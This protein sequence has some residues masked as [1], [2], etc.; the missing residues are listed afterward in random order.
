MPNDIQTRRVPI[1]TVQPSA[2]PVRVHN[3]HQ[4]RKIQRLLK[5]HGQLRPIIV[6]PECNIVD[7]EAV[8]AEMR[9]LGYDEIDIVVVENASPAELRALRL[10]LNR[11]PEDTKWDRAQLRQEFADLIELGFDMELT[12]FETVEIEQSL[13]IDEAP[14]DVVEEVAAA[15]ITPPALIVGQP[16][17]I[18]QLGRHTLACGSALDGGLVVRLVGPGTISAVFTDP[19][20]NVPIGGHVSGLGKTQH[21]EFAMASGE[22]STA[23]F[24][25]F[26]ATAL[27]AC[28]PC[29]AD[30]AILYVAMDWRHVA[31]LAEAGRACGLELKN[32]C[33]WVKTN[34]GMG[35]FYRSQHELIFVFK[36]GTGP[37]QNNFGLG[38]H[39]RHR[40]NVW[41]YAGVNTFGKDRMELL[42]AHPTVKPMQM[43]IDALKDVT[44]RG[45][46]VFDPFLGSGSTLLAAEGT[47]RSC[48]GIELDPGYV[49]I[50]IR[51]WQKLTGKDAVHAETG[52]TFDDFRRRMLQTA[53]GREP[54]GGP[55]S[56]T[57]LV[58]LSL[59]GSEDTEHV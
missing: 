34:A 24:T 58:P 5:R 57:D 56:Q 12:G 59:T 52:E 6:D 27:G 49:E 44:R 1:G 43:I 2:K 50:A 4:R 22:M 9:E 38:Q 39:G 40:T 48:I 26:L 19:P 46:V 29:L 41:R 15:E 11:I 28:T 18:W 47:V 8:Y 32:I 51:R 53:A 33:V 20:Y 42:G 30:G 55:P 54:D 13:A 7:G 16:G 23:Q 31:E 45:D 10:A 37:H 21:R 35:T 3:Q 14:A 25:Q 17:D 36:H